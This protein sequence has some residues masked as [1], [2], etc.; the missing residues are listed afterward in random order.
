MAA[1]SDHHDAVDTKHP[2]QP[3][4]SPRSELVNNFIAYYSSTDCASVPTDAFSSHDLLSAAPLSPTSTPISSSSSSSTATSLVN[5]RPAKKLPVRSSGQSTDSEQTGNG[6]SESSSSLG[7]SAAAAARVLAAWQDR[8]QSSVS[9]TIDATAAS[10]G[11]SPASL[12]DSSAI[13]TAARASAARVQSSTSTP[14]QAASSF[15][16]HAREGSAPV[17]GSLEASNRRPD[18]GFLA[19]LNSAAAYVAE[20]SIPTQHQQH[21]AAD[22]SYLTHG[23]MLSDGTLTLSSIN[24]GFV[25]GNVDGSAEQGDYSAHYSTTLSNAAY[26]D[27]AQ[28]LQHIAATSSGTGGGGIMS[29]AAMD[30]RGH[31]SYVPHEYA[32]ASAHMDTRSAPGI[33]PTQ[34]MPG[35]SL[36]AMKP[37]FSTIPGQSASSASKR[38]RKE[39]SAASESAHTPTKRRASHA[40]EYP[41]GAASTPP[42]PPQSADARRAA[43]KWSEEETT[44]LLQGCTKYGVGAW[45]KI[46]D[47][48]AFAFNNRTSVDLKDRFRTIRAQECAHSPRSKANGK[49]NSSGKEPDVVWPLPPNSQRLQGLQ[50]VQRKPTRNYS[51][52]EDRRLLIG[53]MRHANHWT[54][55]AADPDLKLDDRPGQS[56]R[57]RLRNAFPEVFELFGYV[58]PKKERVDR[59]PCG[60]GTN[61]E[62]ETDRAAAGP[63]RR[64]APTASKR[65]DGTIPEHIRNKILTVLAD[66]NASLDPHP[67]A[68]PEDEGVDS[69]YDADADADGDPGVMDVDSVSPG[70]S[71]AGKSGARAGATTRAAVGKAGRGSRRRST[72]SGELAGT[73]GSAALTGDPPAASA[74]RDAGRNNKRQPNKR[75]RSRSK[76]MASIDAHHLELSSAAASGG[77]LIG[78]KLDPASNTTAFPLP[79]TNDGGIHSAPTHT[80]NPGC[81]PM[82]DL[83]AFSDCDHRR[84]GTLSA[85]A[86]GSGNS[87]HR[88]FLLDSFAPSVFTRPMGTMTPT[89]PLD[90]LAL[91]GRFGSG[92]STPTHSAKRRH[93]VQVDINDA[94]AAVAAGMDRPSF[95]SSLHYFHPSVTG[96]D[97][98]H[99]HHP[100]GASGS[101][102]L[103][104]SSAADTIR[105]MTVGGPIDADSFLFPRIPED[106]SAAAAAAAAAVGMSAQM[107]TSQT[108]SSTPA[109]D[110]MHMPGGASSAATATN[111]GVSGMPTG[112]LYKFP[113]VTAAESSA[114]SATAGSDTRGDAAAGY[115]GQLRSAQRLLRANGVADDNSIGL[116]TT[117]SGESRVDLEALA[118]FNQWFPHFAPANMGWGMGDSGGESIDPNMLDAGLD[119]AMAAVAAHSSNNNGG[120]GGEANMTHARRRSHFDWY[121]LTPSIAAALEAASTSAAVAAQAAAASDDNAMSTLGSFG[122]GQGSLNPSYRRPSM[123]IFPT[124][125]FTPSDML[126][127]TGSADVGADPMAGAVGNGAESGLY[128][129]AASQQD[130]NAGMVAT[131][132][133]DAVAVA[134]GERS[135][136]GPIRTRATDVPGRRRTMHVPPLLL[137]GVATAEFGNPG[138]DSFVAQPLGIGAQLPPH[139]RHGSAPYQAR[140]PTSQTASTSAAATAATTRGRRSRTIS[141]NSNGQ[142]VIARLGATASAIPSAARPPLPP[143]SEAPTVPASNGA[144]LQFP[145]LPTSLDSAA[146]GGRHGRS[147]SGTQLTQDAMSA[148]VPVDVDIDAMTTLSAGDY[149]TSFKASL[150][151]FGDD[152]HLEECVGMQDETRSLIDMRGRDAPALVDLYR[153]A[154]STP[155]GQRYLGAAVTA[156]AS[157]GA[158]SARNHSPALL[159]QSGTVASPVAPRSAA[160]TPGRREAVGM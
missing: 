56:L 135:S 99:H 70:A 61:V 25:Q 121:G 106:D 77:A 112:D 128:G 117:S 42:V 79:M 28:A 144:Q 81:G 103:Q 107:S 115:R 62:T 140:R 75:S 137:E 58:I 134:L 143:V 109:S 16:L 21:H 57:D 126:G 39:P 46:L 40:S 88:N 84:T 12:A 14:R 44:N 78:F 110:T 82:A 73:S 97:H 80:D 1:G 148:L 76:T 100:A 125:G 86:F 101:G 13:W 17:T 66:M 60:D 38:K 151:P 92:Y 89:D 158:G 142:Q 32:S 133:A 63:Q 155:T 90:A 24:N 83:S 120:H 154:S 69:C 91:E 71:R 85:G 118:Q 72:V 22:H 59:E 34:L 5:M 108:V 51:V 152:V 50:R 139:S 94:M 145:L 131:A 33:R 8:P 55:I 156:Q 54:K 123:P 129:V 96:L 30:S 6:S 31:G 29:T 119:S 102:T 87:G 105:R 116:S 64:K 48:P 141:S 27:L 35:D 10:A 74:S 7:D 49:K 95:S 130:G 114:L 124:F 67:I 3:V 68:E 53:V 43:R 9:T 26:Q 104:M 19:L 136:G 47:D 127:M 11:I 2:V 45:K 36:V 122:L 150:W 37:E 15:D 18:M 52:D 65:M 20:S 138:A 113:E 153:P 23:D 149:A 4:A 111:I 132:A 160:S 159:P 157:S 98:H 41:R 93:S 147:F 146:P